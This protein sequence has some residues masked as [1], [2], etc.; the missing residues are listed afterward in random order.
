MYSLMKM[1]DDV[2]ERKCELDW[3]EV[4]LLIILH[5]VGGG[6]NGDIRFQEASDVT[7][8]IFPREV[9]ERWKELYLCIATPDIFQYFYEVWVQT[10]GNGLLFAS[11]KVEMLT[12]S[13]ENDIS[14]IKF[15]AKTHVM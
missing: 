10:T 12:L 8:S 1:V 13:H 14:K 9:N 11:K 2:V 3:F 4:R 6:W 5:N 15:W 7:H